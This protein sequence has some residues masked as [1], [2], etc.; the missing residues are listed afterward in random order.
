MKLL[1]ANRAEIAVRILGTAAALGVPTVAVHPDDDGDCAHVARADEAVRLPGVGAAAYLDLDEIVGAAVRSGCDTLHP[2]YGFLAENPAL[3]RACAD[4][5]IAFVGPD[6]ETLALFGDK[7]RTRDRARELGIPVLTGTEGPTDLATARAF[8]DGL[9]PGGAVMVKA[10]AGGGGRGMRPVTD[11]A[12]LE[13]TMRLCASEAR[14]AFGDDAVY[15]E[16]LLPHARHIEVQV[17]GDGRSTVVLGDRDC[18]AQRSRQK[19]VEIAPAPALADDLRAALHGAATRLVPAHAGLATVEFLVADGQSA[20]LE[21][22]PRIQVEHTVTEE[23]TGFDLVEAGLRVAHGETL[24]DLGLTATPASR[25]TALQVRV[26]TET[27]AADGTV[28]SGAGT[29]V[30]FQPPSGRGVRVDTH[31][32]AGF[33][34][35]PR[36]DSLLAKVIVTAGSVAQAAVRARRALAELDVD[37]V[38]VN[39]ALLR[40]LLDRP[41]LGDGTLDTAFVDAHIAELVPEVAAPEQAPTTAPLGTGAALSTTHGV[42]VAIEVAEGDVVPAGADLVVLEAMKMQHV[43]HAGAPGRVDTVAVKLGDTVAAGVPVAFLAPI[44]DVDAPAQDATATDPDHVRADLAESLG[45]HETGLDA[46]RP[47]ATRRRHEAGRRTARENVDDLLDPDSFVEYGALTIAAQRARRS[48]SDLVAR[49]PADGLITGTG[50]VGGLPVAVM[51]YDY[52]VLAGTQ[53]VHNHAKTDRLFTLA[54]RERLPV[55]IFAE[56]GGGRPGDTDT[57]AVAQLDVPTFRLLAELRG[58]VPTVAVVSGYCFAGNAALAGSCE[59]IIATEGSGL[60]MGGPAM[61]EGGGLGTVAPGDVGPMDVQ[62]ANGVVDVLVPDDPAAVAA[63][64]RYLSYLAPAGGRTTPGEHADPRAL[65]HLV[66]E[67]RLRAYA[68]RPVLAAL[69]DT[70]SVLELRGGFGAGIVTALAR[71]DGRAVGVLANNPEHLGGAIDGDAADKATA[72]LDLCRAHQLP[73]V[74]LCDTPGFMVGPDA[75]RTATVR[76]FSAMFVAGARLTAPLCA[77]VLRK[78]YGLGAMA[79]AGGDL[80]APALTVAWPTGEFGGMGLEGAVRLGYRKELDAIDDPDA[81]RERY[82]ELVATYY[83]RGK[84]LSVAT[85][86]EIDDVV[87]PAETRVLLAR[88]LGR[89]DLP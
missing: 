83:E 49:T 7:T 6:P 75:E 19:L 18:S 74:S 8:L 33:A 84:A 68:I 86:F 63:A 60:G 30:R 42:V 28:T 88:A 71:L 1:V 81:R 20:L 25:G 73:V 62:W 67:N 36:Y 9:G 40:A 10:L 50:T 4:R 80:K 24:A 70:G 23:T 82:D 43:V 59:V 17:L 69:F 27:V 61:I 21:V 56:G 57:S 32:Y 65:R 37:G 53:G 14:A 85:V 3:S 78:A 11:P 87:D 2:G 45:R 39:V 16:Q 89:T 26:N 5:R 47:E 48:V 44:D 58:V 13:A 66:P 29:L 55:V 31:G 38:P 72:F 64:R 77:V 51:S 52:T 34:V 79:M 54:A 41:E 22:N 35:G 15:V 76:R 12:A 46:G